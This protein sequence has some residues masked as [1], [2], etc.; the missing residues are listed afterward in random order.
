[1]IITFDES[2]T[3]F[4]WWV[5]WPRKGAD[6]EFFDFKRAVAQWAKERELEMRGRSIY[7]IDV[8]NRYFGFKTEYDALTFIIVWK[9]SEQ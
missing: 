3:D 8:R 4:Q 7:H 1:M 5:V 9:G 6:Q 2:F